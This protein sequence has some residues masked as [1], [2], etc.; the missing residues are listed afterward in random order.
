MT[1]GFILHM[2]LHLTVPLAVAWLFFRPQFY[3]ASLIMLAGLAIDV[4]HLLANPILDPERCSVGYHLL[5]SYW[6]IPFYLLLTFFPKTRL[7]GLGLMIHI[8]LDWLDC[9]M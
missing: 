6:L 8:L 5:H 1:Q 3:K 9:Y 2:F 4:D 7:F